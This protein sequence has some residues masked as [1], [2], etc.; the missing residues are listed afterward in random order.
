MLYYWVFVWFVCW[1]DIFWR[2]VWFGWCCLC[3]LGSGGDYV[4]GDVYV[5]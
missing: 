3:V 5:M 2:Y 1:V 4:W